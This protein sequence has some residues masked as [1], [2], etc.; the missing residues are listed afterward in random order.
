MIPRTL[1]Y[2]ITDGSESLSSFYT[3]KAARH[4]LKVATLDGNPLARCGFYILDTYNHS[5]EVPEH[6]R[7]RLEDM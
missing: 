5:Y 3:L 4:Y 7:A 2:R 6:L 1:Q